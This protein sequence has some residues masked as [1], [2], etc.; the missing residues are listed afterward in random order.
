MPYVPIQKKEPGQP[1]AQVTLICEWARL[2]SCLEL[3]NEVE[4][5]EEKEAREREVLLRW[6][7]QWSKV[8]RGDKG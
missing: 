4:G 3:A 7:S 5:K 8:T 1:P 6:V 2:H